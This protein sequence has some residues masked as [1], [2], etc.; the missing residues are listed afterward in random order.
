MLADD[1]LNSPYS[2][3]ILLEADM[4]SEKFF[5][6]MRPGN[7]PVLQDTEPGWIIS[8]MIP[9]PAAPE[10]AQRQGFF[11]H[12][13]DSLDQQLQR[14]WEPEELPNN[15]WTAE[16]YFVKNISRSI[17]HEMIQDVT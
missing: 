14:F 11:T 9:S 1:N 16:K 13:N 3:D 15:T 6:M 10:R 7:Y 17:R 8:G 2:N 5:V 4:F 12:N